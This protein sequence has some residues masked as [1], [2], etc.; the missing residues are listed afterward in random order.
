MD[1][2]FWLII[3][4]AAALVAVF[5]G[6]LILARPHRNGYTPLVEPAPDAF[7]IHYRSPY[8]EPPSWQSGTIPS[9]IGTEG[10]INGRPWRRGSDGTPIYLFSGEHGPELLYAPVARYYPASDTLEEAPYPQIDKDMPIVI[11]CEVDYE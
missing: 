9:V 10:V 3:D 8:I 7:P 4:L 2:F 11:E 6:V 1:W 5:I